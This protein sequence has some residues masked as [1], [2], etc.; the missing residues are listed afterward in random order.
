LFLFDCFGLPGAAIPVAIQDIC[1]GGSGRPLFAI[2]R[3]NCD[4]GL[5]FPS[6]TFLLRKLRSEVLKKFHVVVFVLWFWFVSLWEFLC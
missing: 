4:L 6:L 5:M 1:L 2:T 3:G